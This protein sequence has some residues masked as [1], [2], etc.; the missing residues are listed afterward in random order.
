MGFILERKGLTS[1]RCS[2]LRTPALAAASYALSLKIS[3]PPNSRSS[4]PARGTNFLMSG[5]LFSVRLP[6]RIV[7]SCVREPT[8]CAW[9][10]RTN[11][12][13]AMNVVLTAPM[14]GSNTPSF[15]FGDAIFCGFSIRP[16]SLVALS[17]VACDGRELPRLHKRI[18]LRTPRG[19]CKLAAIAGWPKAQAGRARLTRTMPGLGSGS[20]RAGKGYLRDLED[21][22][23]RRGDCWL[24]WRLR[25]PAMTF[26]N[27]AGQRDRSQCGDCQK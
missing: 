22:P 17:A 2:L 16:L 7:P 18:V 3:H 21:R 20:C 23:Q 9:P 15:P 6:S 8:G 5:E 13:P 19:S 25:A 26:Y 10:L 27:R 4:G 24:G 14:P 11:S 1:V 12:T